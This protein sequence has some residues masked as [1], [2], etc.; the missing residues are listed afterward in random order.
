M[1]ERAI[2]LWM[3]PAPSRAPIE[4]PKHYAAHST[5]SWSFRI[6]KLAGIDVYMHVT[7]VLLLGFIGLSQ[8]RQTGDPSAALAGV[9]FFVS[10]GCRRSHNRN[11]GWHLL[12]QRSTS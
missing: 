7:F 2:V 3:K 4:Q 6:G 11:C 5:M 10:N 9:A 12:A 8:W 1:L